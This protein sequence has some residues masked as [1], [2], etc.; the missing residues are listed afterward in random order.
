[1]SLCEFA[2][3]VCIW[4]ISKFSR[5]GDLFWNGTETFDKIQEN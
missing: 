3:L 1:M 4:R 2:L 5:F